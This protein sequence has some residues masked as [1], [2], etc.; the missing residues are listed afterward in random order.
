[1]NYRRT[2]EDV[3]VLVASSSYLDK[4]VGAFRFV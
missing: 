3:G 1:M 4:A 2:G